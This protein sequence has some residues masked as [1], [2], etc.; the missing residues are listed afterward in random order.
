MPVGDFFRRAARGAEERD[1]FPAEQTDACEMK[2]PQAGIELK[3]TFRQETQDLPAKRIGIDG[4]SVR[5]QPH[6]DIFVLIGS[7]SEIAGD[8]CIELT[9]RMRERCSLESRETA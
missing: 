1:E 6:D 4:L 5:S 3:P 8:G 2:I 9:Q 7:K